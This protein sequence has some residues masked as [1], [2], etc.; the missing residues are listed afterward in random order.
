MKQ[1]FLRRARIAGLAFAVLALPSVHA[2]LAPSAGIGGNGGSPFRVDC[3]ESGVLVGLIGRSGEVIDRVG[4]LWVKVEPFFGTMLGGVYETP[5][6]GGPGGGTL[7]KKCPARKVVVGITGTTRAFG[8]ATVVSSLNLVCM[9]IALRGTDIPPQIMAMESTAG[10]NWDPRTA[11]EDVDLCPTYTVS[12]G[13]RWTRIGLAL[14]GSTGNFVARVK[15]VCGSLAFDRPGLKFEVSSSPANGIVTDRAP[16][17]LRWRVS[18]ARPDLMPNTQSTWVLR[19]HNQMTKSAAF[20]M[21]EPSPFRDPCAYAQAPCKQVDWFNFNSGTSVTFTGLPPGRYTLEVTAGPANV[22]GLRAQSLIEVRSSLARAS[23]TESL[24]SNR[25][26][27]LGATPR[28]ATATE[29]IATK[30]RAVLAQGAA[31]SAPV[32]MLPPKQANPLATLPKASLTTPLAQP[33]LRAPSAIGSSFAG[34]GPT[35]LDKPVPK[36]AFEAAR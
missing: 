1:T 22:G 18:S 31:A 13:R 32:L 24:Q 26:G 14:E 36:S 3:G 35:A 17:T 5:G 33:V 29:K 12:D 7:R 4:G 15:V 34:P 8:G 25:L 28:N 10:G 20:G 23:P 2:R 16:V 19:D 6:H 27:A 21:L 30:G 11:K 9:D